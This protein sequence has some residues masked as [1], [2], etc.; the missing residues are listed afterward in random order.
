MAV[1]V[2]VGAITVERTPSAVAEGRRYV[3][4]LL[5]SAGVDHEGAE[6][7]ASEL[8][9]NALDHGGG[10]RMGLLIA[11]D[12]ERIRLEVVDSGGS[13]QTPLLQPD[14][15]PDRERGRGLF[16]VAALSEEWGVI[17]RPEGTTVWAEIL[18]KP[19]A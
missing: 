8:L 9:T 16:L 12:D 2:I 5:A 11:E 6:L 1:M 10:H 19:P 18:R 7:I 3:R 4:T 14:V 15:G 17:S 13:G